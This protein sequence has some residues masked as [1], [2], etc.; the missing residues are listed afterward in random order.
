MMSILVGSWDVGVG[1]SMTM[2][3]VFPSD[4]DSELMIFISGSISLRD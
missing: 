1:K 4:C 2:N 3:I